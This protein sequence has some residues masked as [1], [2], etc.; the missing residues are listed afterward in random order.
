MSPDSTADLSSG[1]PMTMHY[2]SGDPGGAG[3]EAAL[4]S[5]MWRKESGARQGRARTL[6]ENHSSGSEV[7]RCLEAVKEVVSSRTLLASTSRG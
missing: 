2:G 5:L 3:H 7:Y 6:A 4:S 1:R